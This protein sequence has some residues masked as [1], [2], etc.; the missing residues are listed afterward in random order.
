MATEQLTEKFAL[1]GGKVCRPGVDGYAGKYPVIKDVL[2]CGPVSLNKRRYKTTAWGPPDRKLFEGKRVFIDH[3]DARTGRKYREHFGWVENE[4][5]RADGQPIGDIGVKPTHRDAESVLWDAEN[6]PDNCGMSQ[7]AMCDVTRAADGWDDVDLVREVE[8]VD[9]V[10]GP[11]TAKSLFEQ[12]QPGT[13]VTIKLSEWVDR[14]AKLPAATSKHILRGKRLAEMD[15]LADAP[16]PEPA[17]DADPDAALKA[18]FRAAIVLVLDDDSMD[19]A[20]KKKKIGELLTMADKATT[21]ADDT[22]PTETPPTPESVQQPAL[23]NVWESLKACESVGHRPTEKEL[24]LL[25]AN[26]AAD[27]PGLVQEMKRLAA[28]P[29]EPPKSH[30]RGADGT[31]GRVE[32]SK[33]PDAVPLWQD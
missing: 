14:L 9:I 3:T 15:G 1:A 20:A 10:I 21:A 24:R 8:S 25:V 17:A 5:R 7:V 29:A 26:P 33:A 18:G 28:P 27:R 31:N 23:A 4:R 32:E 12:T 6:K 19:L 13:A 2:L 11:A 16:M 30:G 22:P